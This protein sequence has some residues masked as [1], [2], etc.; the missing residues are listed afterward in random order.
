MSEKELLPEGKRAELEAMHGEIVAISHHDGSCFAFKR[1]SREAFDL[2]QKRVARGD[3]NASEM[4]MQYQ[5]VYPGIPDWN[6][7]IEREPFAALSYQ[8][9][10]KECHGAAECRVL[11]ADEIAEQGLD[12][13]LIHITNKSVTFS[14]K[15]PSRGVYKTFQHMVL[16][17]DPKATETLVRNC[18]DADFSKWLD[19][20]L[21][22]ARAFGDKLLEAAGVDKANVVK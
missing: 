10:Y 7:Y 3:D 5:C 13:S 11:E 4:M 17:S 14:F 1:L 15:K 9:A 16:S 22:G 21:F 12:D 6:A 18:G 19:A 2:Y 8:K 20:N